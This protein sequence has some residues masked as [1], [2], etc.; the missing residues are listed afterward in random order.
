MSPIRDDVRGRLVPRKKLTTSRR[1][2]A[3]HSVTSHW[4]QFHCSHVIRNQCPAVWWRGTKMK[5][6]TCVPQAVTV[7]RVLAPPRAPEFERKQRVYDPIS[8]DREGRNRPGPILWTNCP[9]HRRKE[10][11]DRPYRFPRRGRFGSCVSQSREDISS[12]PP[13]RVMPPAESA[14]VG[15]SIKGSDRN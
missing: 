5:S 8:R 9:R 11:L 1:L 4:A 15:V 6:A 14:V 3:L 7:L 2:L 12:T 10:P 13:F